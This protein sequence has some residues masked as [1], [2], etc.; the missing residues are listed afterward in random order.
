MSRRPAVTIVIPA[1]NEQHT[2]ASVLRSLSRQNRISD[3]QVIVVD[4]MSE[5]A[6]AE[7]AETFPFV[8]VISCAPGRAEQMNYGASAADGGVLW[9]LH[10]D[11]TVPERTTVDSM[12]EA[13]EDP[14]LAGGAF[15][16]HL[17]GDDPYY[18][19]VNAVVNLRARWLLRPYGDQ[20]IFVRTE[21]FR[22]LGGYRALENCEDLDLVLRLRQ[23]GRFR[24]LP[25]TVETSARTWQ[26][27]G[28]LRTTLWHLRELMRF[29]W[30]RR[31]GKLQFR[32]PVQEPESSEVRDLSEAGPAPTGS[33]SA[34]NGL[35]SA[36]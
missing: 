31:F 16:F 26:R 24:I 22:S 34:M 13:L 27:Y 11:S 21:L 30:R 28:K 6:T 19:F 17:R 3:C 8:Q 7:T 23:V 12:L 15:R 25:A 35:N 5:D 18:Q 14:D 32:R 1:R 33:S 10:S 4:G 9:F 36:N 2:I 20:G 29:E